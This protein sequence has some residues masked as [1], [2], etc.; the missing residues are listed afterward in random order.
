MYYIQ[1]NSY[2]KLTEKYMENMV[3]IEQKMKQI[4]FW[5]QAKEFNKGELRN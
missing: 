2:F 5:R 4:I 3:N 1:Q